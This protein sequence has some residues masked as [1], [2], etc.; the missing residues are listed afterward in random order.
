[1]MDIPN[2]LLFVRHDKL[3]L[4]INEVALD[5]TFYQYLNFIS[6]CYLPNENVRNIVYLISFL[7]EMSI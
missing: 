4:K 7:N 1:M 6:V 2:I 3:R 5:L